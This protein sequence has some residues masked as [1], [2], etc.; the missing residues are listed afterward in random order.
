MSVTANIHL[1]LRLGGD[2]PFWNS[3]GMD[4]RPLWNTCS[5][6]GKDEFLFKMQHNVFINLFLFF[7]ASQLAA[8]GIKKL[9][10]SSPTGRKHPPKVCF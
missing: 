8:D 1:N 2:D 9:T 6:S 5:P 10:A 7:N 4:R 3:P